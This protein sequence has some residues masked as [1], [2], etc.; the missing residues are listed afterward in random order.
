MKKI[1]LQE[2]SDQELLLQHKKRKKQ[3]MAFAFLIGLQIAAAL[4]ST[5]LKG[6]SFFTFFPLFFI[7]LLFVYF[8][9]QKDSEKELKSRNIE[10][11]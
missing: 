5:Y 11:I 2:L 3:K 8:K 7:P 9:N 1:V 6:M 10:E 4:L